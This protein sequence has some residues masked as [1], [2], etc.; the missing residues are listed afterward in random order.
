MARAA[1]A[2]GIDY[3]ALVKLLVRYALRRRRA[4]SRS[5][6]KEASV[7]DAARGASQGASG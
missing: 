4:A 5:T 1:A 6:G 7:V 2:V 3:A